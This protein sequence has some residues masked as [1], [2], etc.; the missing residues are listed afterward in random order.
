MK[1]NKITSILL[2]SILYSVF[3]LAQ[4]EPKPTTDDAESIVSRYARIMHLKW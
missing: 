3:A 2:L 1:L 4:E